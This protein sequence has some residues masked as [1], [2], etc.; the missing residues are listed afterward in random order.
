MTL[1]EPN[2]A[3]RAFGQWLAGQVG[4]TD[5]EFHEDVPQGR[6]YGAGI[7]TEVL[8]HVV[9]PP[10][11]IREMF[12]LLHPGGVVF[13]TSSFGVPQ[14]S[15]LKQNLKYAGKE[16]ELMKAAGFRSWT[17]PVKSPVPMF[18]QWGFWQRPA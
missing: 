8:E 14:D 4:F 16:D 12:E 2:G 18:P 17:P 5:M 3:A 1:I 10:K 13:V 9:D 7:C 11:M 6:R 15:H